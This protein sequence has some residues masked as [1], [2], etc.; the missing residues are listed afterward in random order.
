MGPKREE[1]FN[2]TARA[3]ARPIRSANQSQSE[4]I[5][6]NPAT[7]AKAKA[8][9]LYLGRAFVLFCA[10]AKPEN[11]PAR[12]A[13]PRPTFAGRPGPRLHLATSAHTH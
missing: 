10:A 1:V 11:W 9:P 2:K 7:D 13:G 8:R 12:A 3:R 5:K 4:R 6:C